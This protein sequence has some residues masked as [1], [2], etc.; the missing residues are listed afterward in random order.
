MDPEANCYDCV[1]WDARR[2]DEETEEGAC[3][4]YSPRPR[5]EIPDLESPEN[6]GLG[7]RFVV[8]PVTYSDNWCGEFERKPED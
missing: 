5:F 1:F 3:R 2:G 6:D 4:R 7:S 8:W